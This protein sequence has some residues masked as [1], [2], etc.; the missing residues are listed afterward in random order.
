[1]FKAIQHFFIQ[2]RLAAFERGFDYDMAYSRAVLRAST[3]GFRR[4]AALFDLAAYREGVPVEAWYA[5]KWAAVRQEDC[6]PCLQLLVT[7]AQ[8]DGV[9]APLLRAL[10]AEDDAAMGAEVSHVYR[11]AQQALLPNPPDMAALDSGREALLQRYGEAG[12]VALTM[13]M[14]ASRSFPF[15]KRALGY[16]HN[17]QR[18]QLDG[19][20]LE[21]AEPRHHAGAPQ[22]WGANTAR[23]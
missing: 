12:L 4:F 8:R 11:W 13:A 15:V 9:S 23:A 21:S 2:R 14:A 18:I 10:W 20:W 22:T 16:A 5:A 19:A 3:R 6:G 17:C 7:M 1:M